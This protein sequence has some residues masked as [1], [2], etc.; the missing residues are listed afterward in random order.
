VA[1]DQLDF[2]AL[3]TRVGLD[4][5][6]IVELFDV[7][8]TTSEADLAQLRS[9]VV[10]ENPDRVVEAA[11]SIKGAAMSLGLIHLSRLALEIEYVARS[12]TI[13]GIAEQLP[14]LAI[15]L[16]EIARLGDRAAARNKD[17]DDMEEH[18]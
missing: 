5:S 6:M 12:G 1:E 15:R 18:R 13:Q 11:H 7:F 9:A 17:R 10:D 2:D 8:L 16:Q 3:A 14:E 4:R